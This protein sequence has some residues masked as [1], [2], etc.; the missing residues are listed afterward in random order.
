M[1]VIKGVINAMAKT[2]FG[3]QAMK[4]LV[5]DGKLAKLISFFDIDEVIFSQW[6]WMSHEERVLKITMAFGAWKTLVYY[7]Q[8]LAFGSILV[9]FWHSKYTT[10]TNPTMHLSHIPQCA[11]QYRNVHI[12][13]MVYGTGALWGLWDWSIMACINRVEWSLEKHKWLP[14]GQF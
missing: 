1:F 4:Q 5:L 3:R 13:V 14:L 12:P 2:Y 8:W 6:S 7:Y 11:I 9:K 10:S